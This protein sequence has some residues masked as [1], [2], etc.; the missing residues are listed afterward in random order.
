MFVESH[1]QTKDW[2]KNQE[3]Y[4][5]GKSNE[6]EIF[7]RQEFEKIIKNKCQK[8]NKRLNITTY[9]LC[10]ISHPLK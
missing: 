1:I 10:E 4:Y 7:Q 6:C 3:W 8:S 9:E 5:N 2:R